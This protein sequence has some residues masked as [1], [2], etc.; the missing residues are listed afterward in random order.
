MELAMA[1]APNPLS[2][3]T[4]DTP[5]RKL[6]SI[7]SSAAIRRSWPVPDARRHGDHGHLH[8][9]ADHARQRAFHPRHHDDD[10]G[11]R[12]ARVLRQESMEPGN[13]DVAAGLPVSHELGAHGCFLGHGRSAVPA[14]ATR[15]VPRPDGVPSAASVMVLAS[16][17]NFA[18]ARRFTTASYEAR[19]VRVTSRL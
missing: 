14:A 6:F 8:E 3:L 1:A 19:S 18:S 17:W 16:S 2:M 9:A 7:D 4:T 11:G 5:P 13:P 10:A 12:E 15:I